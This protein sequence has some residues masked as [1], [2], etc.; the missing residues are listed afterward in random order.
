MISLFSKK[1]TQ[2]AQRFVDAVHAV[3]P[4]IDARIATPSTVELRGAEESR[5]VFSLDSLAVEC[6]QSDAGAEAAIG[7][8]VQTALRLLRPLPQ[9]IDLANVLPMLKPQGWAERACAK[10]S[11]RPCTLSAGDGI[12]RLVIEE[13]EGQLR[14]VA[15]RHLSHNSLDAE[16]L[17]ARAL[18]NFHALAASATLA[19]SEDDD[20]LWIASLPGRFSFNA[21]L[22]LL[23]SI[24]RQ[25]KTSLGDDVVCAVPEREFCIFARDH[26]V[27][28]E[29]RASLAPQLFDAAA[30]PV[31]RGVYALHD[32][33]LLRNCLSP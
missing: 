14:F 10:P 12:E 23:P 21:T 7:R 18:T 9:E 26:A 3:D 28:E 17:H 33:P 11:E 29:L 31:A 5:V 2:L 1:R 20:S 15:E 25:A 4:L 30:Y 8:H 32:G 19:P 13:V 27:V 24:W 16:A 22:A 6:K